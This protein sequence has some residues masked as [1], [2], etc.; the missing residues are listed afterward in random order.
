LSS[1]SSLYLAHTF[2]SRIAPQHL[3]ATSTHTLAS[4]LP[5]RTSCAS[6]SGLI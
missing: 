6:R 2:L 4:G 5:A 3:A 1:L